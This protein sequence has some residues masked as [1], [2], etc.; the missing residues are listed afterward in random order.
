MF[1]CKYSVKYH[2]YASVPIGET[3]RPDAYEVIDRFMEYDDARTLIVSEAAKFIHELG[4]DSHIG[5]IDR[6]EETFLTVRYYE[7]KINRYRRFYLENS[8]DD[9]MD[10]MEDYDE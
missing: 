8:D 9:A 3:A 10:D 5:I 7:G 2:D 4:D 1:Q 6:I